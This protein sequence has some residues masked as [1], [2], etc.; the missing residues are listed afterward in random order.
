M[1][2][3]R[4][5][6]DSQRLPATPKRSF[7]IC[8]FI[9]EFDDFCDFTVV[10]KEDGAV[11]WIRTT[12]V[13]LPP[14]PQ[15]GASASS[16]T[17]AQRN[18]VSYCSRA[19]T[20]GQGA[21]PTRVDDRTRTAACP[22]PQSYFLTGV[23]GAGVCGVEDCGAGCVG[24]GVTGPD[25]AGAGLE[26]CWRMEPPE[27]TPRSTRTTRASAQTMNITAHQVVACDRTLAAPRGPK[28]VWLPAPPKAPARSAALP[29][30]SRTTMMSTRQFMTKNVVSSQ[31]AQRNPTIMIA[32]PTSSA[33]VHFIQAGISYTSILKVHTKESIVSKISPQ[34][35]KPSKRGFCGTTRAVPSRL[36]ACP[37]DCW[38][39]QAEL[40]PSPL[41]TREWQSPRYPRAVTGANLLPGWRRTLGPDLRRL[42]A[43][44]PAL[45]APSIPECCQA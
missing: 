30:C 7:R 17:T 5:I 43:R 28:A 32:K 22:V 14:A 26:Y 11:E 15:A 36:S 6:L 8:S 41:V 19:A 45:S 1:S 44:H 39:A 40:K 12:T 21:G 42:R 27:S 37:Y 10:Q 13:L 20:N 16:A 4:G 23:D 33:T 38:P 9:G 35:Q 24:T 2:P 34:G 29:L 31:G 25:L 18:T 3:M